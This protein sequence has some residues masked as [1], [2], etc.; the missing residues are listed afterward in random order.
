MIFCLSR[1]VQ[2]RKEV[3][4]R[5]VAQIICILELEGYAAPGVLKRS[6]LERHLYRAGYG[7][8]QMQM[9]R[10]ARG[11]SSKRFCKPHRMMLVQGDIKYG[12]KLSIGKNGARVQTYL[13]SAIDDHSRLLLA[14]RFYDSQEEAIV[15]DTFRQA[16]LDTES[17]MPATLITVPSISPDRSGSLFQDWGSGSPCKTAERQKQRE[18]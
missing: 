7:R 14:S 10:D 1:R 3:P 8:E 9:Y 18:D 16:I 4:E 15:E 11:S 2:L 5:S 17:L 6:T 12:P 13:S